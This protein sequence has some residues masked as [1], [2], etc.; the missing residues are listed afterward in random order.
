MNKNIIPFVCLLLGWSCGIF[1]GAAEKTP[2]KPVNSPD[3]LAIRIAPFTV[4]PATQPVISVLVRN[5]GRTAWQGTISLQG[6]AG[7]R[8]AT[9][10][11]TVTLEA[12]ALKRLPFT[13]AEGINLAANRYAM[14]V[15]A[16][17]PQGTVK[18][19]QEVICAS[20]P[21]YKAKVDGRFDEWGDA[22]P[23]TFSVKGKKTVINAYWNRRHL[24]FWVSVWEDRL[25]HFDAV[26]LAVAPGDGVTSPSGTANTHRFEF[27][28]MK[29][30]DGTAGACYQLT[31]PGQRLQDTQK[32]KP[33]A[34]RLHAKADVAVIR[35]GGVTHY[36]CAIPWGAMRN[37]IRPTEGREFCLSFLIHDPDGTGI[38]DFG[39]A[40]GL[41]PSE[42]RR[43]AW[44]AWPGVQW[45]ETPPFDGKIRWGLC[46]SKH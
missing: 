39:A 40:A 7:F 9:P 17:G 14:V 4:P 26:Q 29:S 46:S 44:S 12:G 32:E 35:A 21:Y 20:A 1:A 41:W 13:I 36:E 19:T 24:F 27:L 15:T 23:I 22:I 33:L 30:G 37:V 38:R 10:G 31:V 11:R 8:I 2:P 6:P 16:T 3:G 25:S 34:A 5:K 18:H 28:L 42:R 45:G 43:L